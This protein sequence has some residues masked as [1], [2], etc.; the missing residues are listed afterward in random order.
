MGIKTRTYTATP[1]DCYEFQPPVVQEQ[2]NYNPTSTIPCSYTYGEWNACSPSGIQTRSYTATPTGCCYQL[3]LPVAQQAC[4]YTPTSTIPC[5]YSYG[6]WSV[7]SS[8]G[9]KTRTYT[10][11]PTGCYQL[12]VP[13]VQ[14]TCTY[15]APTST[16]PCYYTYSNWS[17]CNIYSYQTR[18][19]LSKYPTECSTTTLPVISQNCTY[20]PTST[21]P[22]LYSYG[23][24]SACNT[25]G[26]KTRTYTA[27]PTGCYQSNTPVLHQTCTSTVPCS[28]YSYS[29]WS[30]CDKYGYQTRSVLSKYPAGCYSKENPTL[31]RECIYIPEEATSTN[32]INIPACKYE[33]SVWSDCVSDRKTRMVIAKSPAECSE[34]IAPVLY[35]ACKYIPPVFE[36]TRPADAPAPAPEVVLIPSPV[37]E[38]DFNGKTSREWQKYYFGSES[39]K[40]QSVCGGL[41]DPDKDGLINDEEYRFGTDPKRADSDHDGYVDADEIQKGRNPLVAPTDDKQDKMAF[42]SPKEKGEVKKDLYQVSNVEMVKNEKENKVLKITGKALANTYVTVYVYSDPIVLTIKTDA[43]GNWSYVLD[44]PLDDGEHQVYV[45]V[46]DNVGKIVAKSEPIVFVQTAEA[47]VINTVLP[48]GVPD[49]NEV[50]PT[51][52]WFK[53][54]YSI[55]IILGILGLIMSLAVIGLIRTSVKKPEDYINK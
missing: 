52:A 18:T 49:K 37:N 39:C 8:S 26:V 14:Q 29:E 44:K 24:W 19:V 9:V 20:T 5:L 48:I 41:A 34:S 55:F 38:T 30:A 21:V 36:I 33:Y 54:N 16:I 3:N 12:D 23:E 2:C 50:S 47:A 51:K 11:T 40:N 10:A 7:C 1:T 43:D 35:Q 27:M 53:G 28:S 42:E 46:T 15:T 13:V 4:T 17:A 25:S 32:T 31:K 45:A 22:C 6:E